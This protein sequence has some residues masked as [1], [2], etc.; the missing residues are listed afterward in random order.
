MKMPSAFED[1][2]KEINKRRYEA[3]FPKSPKQ[4]HSEC[5]LLPTAAHR[6]TQ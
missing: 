1:E 4:L 2:W 3:F 5:I 6:V